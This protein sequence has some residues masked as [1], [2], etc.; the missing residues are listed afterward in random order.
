MLTGCDG[1]GLA[2]QEEFADRIEAAGMCAELGVEAEG[3]G[4]GENIR[5]MQRIERRPS[6]Q[7][8]FRMQGPDV[9]LDSFELSTDGAGDILRWTDAELRDFSR[10]SVEASSLLEATFAS[11]PFMTKFYIQ[12][13]VSDMVAECT[14]GLGED[15][16]KVELGSPTQYHCL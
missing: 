14:F 12:L 15:C 11:L 8:G 13:K 16:L 9:D 10:L 5:Q 4:W 1:L 2:G 7:R 6:L 3:V